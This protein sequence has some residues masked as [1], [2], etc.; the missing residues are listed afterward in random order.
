MQSQPLRTAIFSA[1]FLSTAILQLFA[2][3]PSKAATF[4]RI[5]RDR[6]PNNIQANTGTVVVDQALSISGQLS[7]RQ[8]SDLYAFTVNGAAQSLVITSGNNSARLS[9]AVLED[10]NNNGR[11]DFSDR[12]V[13]LTSAGNNTQRQL[14]IQGKTRLLFQV[15]GNS[16]NS[17]AAYSFR[18]LPQKQR[19]D[20]QVGIEIRGANVKTSES[21]DNRTFSG[22]RSARADFY[23]KVNLDR[24]RLLKTRTI[25]NNDFPIFNQ[26]AFRKIPG[27]QGEV[28]FEITMMDDDFGR[29]DQADISPGSA[30]TFKVRYLIATGEIVGPDNQVL[31]QM[32]AG[33]LGGNKISPVLRAAGNDRK[34]GANLFFRIIHKGS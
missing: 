27:T 24:R 28:K 19:R 6:E 5:I 22:G 12:V 14:N 10:T 4:T 17:A 26:S 34:R 16:R 9:Y 18:L 15:F 20:S 29:D 31:G 32:G 33:P 1:L 25:K 2:P 11:R 8:D 30:R 13:L 21:F 3:L 23:V 7:N